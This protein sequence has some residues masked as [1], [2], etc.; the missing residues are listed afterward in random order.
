MCRGDI[1]SIVCVV[2][3]GSVWWL[4]ILNCMKCDTQ[5]ELEHSDV[6]QVVSHVLPRWPRCETSRF[7]P[8]V[9]LV[10]AE[11]EP[12]GQVC[13]TEVVVVVVVVIVVVV[14]VIVVV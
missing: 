4:Q 13:R 8:T 5:T 9:L 7:C 6:Y 10:G 11:C 3:F 2:W 14:V 1:P 12:N